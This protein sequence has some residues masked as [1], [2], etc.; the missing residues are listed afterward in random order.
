LRFSLA[1]AAARGMEFMNYSRLF[2]S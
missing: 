1:I 2:F